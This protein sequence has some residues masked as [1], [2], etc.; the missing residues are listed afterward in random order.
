[1]TDF[2]NKKVNFAQSKLCVKINKKI[3]NNEF[4]KVYLCSDSSNP[5]VNYTMKVAQVRLDDK[6]TCN[7]INTEIIMLVTIFLK[8]AFYEKISEHRADNRLLFRRKG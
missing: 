8:I 4:Y 3:S 1:M 2:I 6:A 5:S 7:L